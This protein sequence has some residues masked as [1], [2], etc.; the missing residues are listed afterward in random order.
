[1]K[2]RLKFT[3]L[4]GLAISLGGCILISYLW[5]RSNVWFRINDH[6]V[7]VNGVSL[8]DGSDYSCF[9]SL[10]GDIFCYH[11]DHG[12]QYFISPKLSEVSVISP[13]AD[14]G[15]MDVILISSGARTRFENSNVKQKLADSHLIVG[16]GFVEF[17]PSIPEWRSGAPQTWHISY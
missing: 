11:Q 4:K 3:P 10:P 13:D 16:D 14:V 9:K 1:M 7:L 8:A 15:S 17:T 2:N 12:T 5:V 6:R